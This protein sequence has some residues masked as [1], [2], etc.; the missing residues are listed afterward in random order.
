MKRWSL[1]IALAAV[2][3]CGGEAGKVVDESTENPQEPVV[4]SDST[5]GD[6]WSIGAFDADRDG[7]VT[8]EEFDE[9]WVSRFDDWDIDTDQALDSDE[10][11]TMF[12]ELIDLDENYLITRPEWDRGTSRWVFDNLD[13]GEWSE[14]NADGDERLTESEWLETW[15]SSRWQSWDGDGDGI[16]GEKELEGLFF[17]RF[18]ENGDGVIA[19]GEA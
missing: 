18:D 1:V 2:M 12:W 16:I 15:R 11:A 4:A 3:S 8:R 13:W 7:E 10:L 14:W 17:D 6:Q 5:A 19:A 9:I